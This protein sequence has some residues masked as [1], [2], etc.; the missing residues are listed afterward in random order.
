MTPEWSIQ[1]R[2]LQCS[3]TGQPF[4]EGQ[5]FYT[6]LF[7]DKGGYRREDLSEE[8]FAARNDNI[9]P[10]SLWKSKFEPPAPPAPE[11]L[12]KQTAED[13]LRTYMQSNEP[14]KTNVCYLLAVM[15][16]RKR[17]LR[18]TDSQRGPDGQLT[19]I[20]EHT[21]TGEVF[22]IPDP[23]LRLDQIAEVQQQVAGLLG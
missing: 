13:L 11:P 5:Y 17:I 16:E 6:L 22:I 9:Q 23:Q 21:K 12:G 1:S 14:Q 3:I 15:L 8:A 2:A 4:E 18:E 20:Y 19:R 7:Y 10:F